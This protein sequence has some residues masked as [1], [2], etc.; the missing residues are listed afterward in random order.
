MKHSIAV[1][2]ILLSTTF[3]IAQK[4]EKIKGSKTVTTKVKEISNFTNL[5]VSDNIEVFL[6]KGE[7]SVLKIEADDNLQ[8]QIAVTTVG[9]TLQLQTVKNITRFTKLI[10][11]ITYTNE[12]NSITVKND[13]IV[14]AI[15]EIHSDNLSIKSFDDS[16]LFLNIVSNNFN[17]ETAQKSTI[18]LNL[19]GENAK[20]V[21]SDNSELKALI[22]GT[23]FACDMYQKSKAKIEGNSDTGTIRI[24]ND[25]KLTAEKLQIKS[26]NLVA[27]Q[28]SEGSINAEKEIV[29]SAS[30]RAEIQLYGS[31]KIT[32]KR[33]D[34]EAKLLKKK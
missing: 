8:D 2:L 16:K 28:G 1:I 27:E 24:D 26:I 13:A 22:K 15:Q 29:I 6:E 5:E 20:I 33:F 14:N 34:D 7:F 4:K 9:S 17:L 25:S 11:R 10:V 21:M 30:E 19:K 3:S 23:D 12:I 32:L 18:E 31:P